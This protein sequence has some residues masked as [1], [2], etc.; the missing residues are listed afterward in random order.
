M[1][2]F[3]FYFCFMKISFPAVMGIVNLTPDS[4][5]AG[6]RAAHAAD[7]LERIE[8]MVLEG[9]DIV[10]IG[11]CSTRPGALRASE[12][13]EWQ[14]LEPV[15]KSLRKHFPHVVFS[16]DT[17]RS[18]IVEKAYDLIGSFWVNDIMAGSAD[19]NMVPLVARLQLPWIA[20]HQEPFEGTQGVARFFA[21]T[22]RT[23]TE[24]GVKQVFLDPGFGFNKDT[25]Q[26]FMVLNALPSL[27]PTDSSGTPAAP[28]LVG[29]SRKRMTYKPLH[30]T[31]ENALVATSALHLHLLFKGVSVLRVHDVKPAKEIIV[32]YKKMSIF[33]K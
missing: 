24:W 12:K 32:L 1:S 26:N 23:A 31:P 18:G 9:A 6:S 22:I 28:L 15:L 2:V 10:D 17:F 25:N 16:I 20:M 8:H 21:E 30:T 14:R 3:F 33:E 13:E 27:V 29:I 7:A 5:Y 11:A 19:T 4:F